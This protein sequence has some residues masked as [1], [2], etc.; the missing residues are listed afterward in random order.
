MPSSGKWLGSALVP[1]LV[2]LSCAGAAC[3]H[4]HGSSGPAADAQAPDGQ[5]ED[6][7]SCADD[8]GFDGGTYPLPTPTSIQFAAKAALPSGEQLLINDWNAQPNTVSS[9]SPD[10]TTKTVIFE[11][12]LA[13]SMG[14]S[15]D[16]KS[17]AF[18]CGDPT[19]QADFGLQI[20]NSINQ[21][22]IYDVPTQTIH[23]VSHGNLDD[24]CHTFGPGD[25]TLWVCR[26][27]DFQ[28]TGDGGDLMGTNKGYRIGRIDLPSNDFTFLT[29][30]EPD[31]LALYPQP[32]ADG[33]SV[34]Y[35]TSQVVSATQ[36]NDTVELMPLPCGTASSERSNAREPVLSPDGTRYV[37]AD[38]SQM[39]ALYAS[40]L[41]GTSSVRLTSEAGTNA[42]WSP[43]GTKVAYL[44]FDSTADCSHLDVVQSDGSSATSPTR[45]RD[46]T[47]TGEFITELAWF[48]EP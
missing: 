21:S 47:K 25:T 13:W 27:Y 36:T 11:V 4:A 44:V 29:P 17:I 7:A 33:G 2:P 5:G 12:F 35:S 8:A 22:W 14:V 38:D 40:N 20:E 31:D 30:D 9:L 48:V 15:H 41:D 23:L 1:W 43:D 10:G 32:T 28:E 16:G 46:C 34:Y 45:L 18:S 19:Q 42:A 39:G 3:G 26:R 37:Y 6:A 24:E